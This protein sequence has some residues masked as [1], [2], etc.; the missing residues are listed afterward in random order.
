[1]MRGMSELRDTVT[2]ELDHFGFFGQAVHEHVEHRVSRR[3]A[4]DLAQHRI[5]PM[6]LTPC[7]ANLLDLLNLWVRL[8]IVRRFIR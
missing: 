2:F 1:M 3:I 7:L 6:P 8:L 5:T 4:L